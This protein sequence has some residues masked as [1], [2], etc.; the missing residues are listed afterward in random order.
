MNEINPDPYYFIED[1]P[2]DM[3]DSV[4]FKEKGYDDYFDLLEDDDDE[5]D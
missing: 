3:R 2:A 1:D 5:D 4:E